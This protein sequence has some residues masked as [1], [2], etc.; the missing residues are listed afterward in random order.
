[1]LYFSPFHAQKLGI[2]GYELVTFTIGCNL[3][4]KCDISTFYPVALW[5]ERVWETETGG[6]VDN[7]L[8]S[9]K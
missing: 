6:A 5:L 3:S 7:H 2:V 1:M 4:V 9:G 8:I